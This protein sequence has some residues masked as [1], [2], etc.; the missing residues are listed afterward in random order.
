MKDLQPYVCTFED[1]QTASSQYNSLKRLDE[2]ERSAHIWVKASSECLFCKV[3]VSHNAVRDEVGLL[4]YGPHIGQHLEE[5]AFLASPKA[6]GDWDF[7]SD[8]SSCNDHPFRCP[9]FDCEEVY[10]T[11]SDLKWVAIYLDLPSDCF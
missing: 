11:I 4:R 10:G 3:H 7:Y 6:H 8:V 9:E 2:H 1:C 5:I